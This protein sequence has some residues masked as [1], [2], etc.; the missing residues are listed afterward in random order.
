MEPT[1]L[2]RRFTSTGKVEDYLA[3]RRALA[4]EKKNEKKD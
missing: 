3:Y 1:E 4:Q 2:W